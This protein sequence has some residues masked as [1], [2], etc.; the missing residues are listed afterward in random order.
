MRNPDPAPRTDTPARSTPPSSARSET[1]AQAVLR[2]PVASRDELVAGWAAVL[3][4]GD[5][6]DKQPEDAAK[7]DVKMS[8]PRFTAGAE[9]AVFRGAAERITQMVGKSTPESNGHDPTLDG[10]AVNRLPSTTHAEAGM[11]CRAVPV[12]RNP[13]RWRGSARYDRPRHDLRLVGAAAAM[14]RRRPARPEKRHHRR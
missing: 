5:A 9:R 3:L 11:Y 4:A 10:G 2:A 12:Q 6:A 14:Q 1:P 7:R 8:P 13:Y